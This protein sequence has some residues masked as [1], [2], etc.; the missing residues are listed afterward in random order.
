MAKTFE[1]IYEG[2]ADSRRIKVFENGSRIA[3]SI[4]YACDIDGACKIL[5]A[6]GYLCIERLDGEMTI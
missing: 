6:L 1:V 5:E 4:L 3:E 2:Y